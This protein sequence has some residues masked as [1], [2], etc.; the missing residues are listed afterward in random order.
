MH[1]CFGYANQQTVNSELIKAYMKS[2]IKI[3]NGN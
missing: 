1:L 3:A 2:S